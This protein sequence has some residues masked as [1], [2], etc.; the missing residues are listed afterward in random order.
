MTDNKHTAGP[1]QAM[2]VT[3][4]TIIVLN[5]DSYP[6]AFVPG[7]TD[8]PE[9]TSEAQ[10]NARLIAA[11]P[12]MLMAL[13][14]LDA[15][16]TETFPDGPDGDRRWVGGLGTLSD[17]TVTIWRTIRAAIAKATTPEN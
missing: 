2:P 7:W 17:E 16:W 11:A 13:Q 1:W 4:Q 14:A 3:G 9:T 6:T 10:A 8:N 12:D 5:Y 15:S